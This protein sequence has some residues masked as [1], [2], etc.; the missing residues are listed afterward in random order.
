MFRDDGE[1]ADPFGFRG[2]GELPGNLFVRR[3][4][5]HGNAFSFLAVAEPIADQGVAVG[6]PLNSGGPMKARVGNVR[7]GQ[8]PDDFVVWGNLKNSFF[9]GVEDVAIGKFLN[10][11]NGGVGGDGAYDLPAFKFLPELG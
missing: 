3:D 7:C 1:G 11:E 2:V 4:F 9:A 6:E 10:A 8:I 5:E